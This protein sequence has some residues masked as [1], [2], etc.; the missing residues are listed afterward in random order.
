[1]SNG[2][3]GIIIGISACLLLVF[4]AFLPERPA[5]STEAFAETGE[6]EILELHSMEDYLAFAAAVRGGITYADTYVNLGTDLDFSGVT[7]DPVAGNEEYHFEGIF[8]GNGH[9]IRN[10]HIQAEYAGLFYGLKG[11]VANLTVES[12]TIEGTVCGAIASSTEATA[13]ILNCASWAQVQGDT[14]NGIAGDDR[15]IVRNCAAD[16]METTADILNTDL[17][18]LDTSWGLAGF[19]RWQGGDRP[20]L[21][22]EISDLIVSVDGTF[23]GA[24]AAPELK[25]YYAWEDHAWRFV[26]PKACDGMDMR[27]VCRYENKDT[28]ELMKGQDTESLLLEHGSDR[29]RIEFQTTGQLPVLMTETKKGLAWIQEDKENGSQGSLTLYSEDG[30]RLYGGS[31]EKIAGHGND[32]WKAEKKS[33]NLTLKES[34]DLL[35][36]GKSQKYVL[37]AGY[38]DNSMMAYK[39]TYDMT[40]EIGMAY[41]PENELVHVYIDGNYL[42]IYLLVGRIEIGEDRFDLKNLPEM[43]KKSNPRS[44]KEYGLTEQRAEDGKALRAW[45]D[46]PRTPKDLTGGYILELTDDYDPDKS[47]FVSEHNVSMTLKSQPYASKEQVD[48]AADL[49]QEFENALFAEDGVNDKGRH[50]SEYIDMESFADQWLFYELNEENSLGS[51]VYFYKDSDETGDGLIHASWMWDLEHSLARSSAAAMSWLT[52]VR[53]D[54]DEYWA[55]FYRHE[56]FR[57]LVFKEWQE[58]FLPA[59]E[60]ALDPAT[61]EDPDGIS[62]LDWYLKAYEEDG[63]LEHSR[64]NSSDFAEKLQKIRTIF[65]VRKEFLTRALARCEDTVHEYY[66]EKD[67]VFYGVRYDGGE[68]ALM[69]VP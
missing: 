14:Y 58:K 44:F 8:D 2:Q 7:E 29:I 40:R 5:G 45:Y 33:Y 38:R 62:S 57:E 67:G 11:T 15:A 3:K 35:G 21:T 6:Q 13:R 64:W 56:D 41:A 4:L 65:E 42:G 39:V 66:Y 32:S 19:C 48:Y 22:Q 34:A 10:L 1:M 68:D 12:G 54:P 47:R 9:Q 61:G 53:N 69:E 18:G 31:L 30:T 60:K 17:T 43:T 28:E 16:G 55:Q 36:I 26:L 20:V 27:I 37:L 49:W 59:I 46:L 51:S 23:P 63:A 24:E 25:A 52:S 50:Y